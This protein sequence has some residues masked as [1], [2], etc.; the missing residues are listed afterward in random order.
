MA[1]KP[2][3][4][5]SLSKSLLVNI[6]GGGNRTGSPLVLQQTASVQ[7]KQVTPVQ[8]KKQLNITSPGMMHVTRPW[9]PDVATPASSLRRSTRNKETGIHDLIFGG[10]LVYFMILHTYYRYKCF[11]TYDGRTG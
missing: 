6:K 10:R 3:I 11:D 5:S 2:K 4:I 1:P 8:V 9:T 7:V